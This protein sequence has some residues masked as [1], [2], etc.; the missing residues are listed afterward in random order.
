MLGGT[1]PILTHPD[2]VD[3]DN[4]LGIY[5]YKTALEH[6]SW[7]SRMVYKQQQVTFY[8][9]CIRELKGSYNPDENYIVEIPTARQ[10]TKVIDGVEWGSCEDA[11]YQEISRA[12]LDDGSYMPVKLHRRVV[13]EVEMDK[14]KDEVITAALEVSDLYRQYLENELSKII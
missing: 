13:T 9:M 5:E 1:I 10:S 4:S 2:S 8:Q 12:I 14:L 11:K 6:R 3:I 7:N